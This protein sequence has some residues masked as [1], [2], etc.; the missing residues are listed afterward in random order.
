MTSNRTFLVLPQIKAF[1]PA[2]GP[3]GTQVVITGVSLTQTTKVAFG[4]KSASFT[5]NSDSQVTATVPTGAKTGKIKITTPGGI[6]TSATSF[7]VT[8]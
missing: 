2:S 8:Q 3:V 7:T 1:A 4:A 6:A 5:V